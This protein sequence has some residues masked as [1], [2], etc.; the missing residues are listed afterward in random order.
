M[1]IVSVKFTSDYTS[2]HVHPAAPR[3][4]KPSH[5]QRTM[6]KHKVGAIACN[7]GNHDRGTKPNYYC[8]KVVKIMVV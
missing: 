1:C 2:L 5:K 4:H 6:K 3:T 8:S 7:Y